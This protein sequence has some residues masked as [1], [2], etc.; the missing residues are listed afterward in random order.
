MAD[1]YEYNVNFDFDSAIE[2]LKFLNTNLSKSAKE[3]KNSAKTIDLLAQRMEEAAEAIGLA[4][5]NFQSYLNIFKSFGSAVGTPLQMMKLFT[6]AQEDYNKAIAQGLN[7]FEAMEAAFSRS[8]V[9]KVVKDTRDLVDVEKQL[10][11]LK[12]ERTKF[13][14]QANKEARLRGEKIPYPKA[15]LNK[16]ERDA[17]DEGQAKKEEAARQKANAAKV[18]ESEK[19]YDE[20]DSIIAE[21]LSETEAREK[22]S[23]DERLKA[24]Q[25]YNKLIA[26][27]I[28]RSKVKSLTPEKIKEL[29]VGSEIQKDIESGGSQDLKAAYD[30]LNKELES[31][32]KFLNEINDIANSNEEAIANAKAYDKAWEDAQKELKEFN[33][34]QKKAADDYDNAWRQAHAQLNKVNKEAED[35]KTKALEKEIDERIQL[36]KE[37]ISFE[38]SLRDKSKDQVGNISPERILRASK[39]KD[40]LS[41]LDE[42]D[43]GFERISAAIKEHNAD[44]EKAALLQ[45]K[46]Q[47]AAKG[48]SKSIEEVTLS[49][50]AMGRIVAA[51]LITQVFFEMQSA[52]QR[53]VKEAADLYNAIAEIQTITER[54]SQGP[55]EYA[56]SLERVLDLSSRL[57]FTPQDTANAVY[58]ALSNQI[59]ETTGELLNFIEVSGR[60]AKT[61]RSSLESASDAIS[62]VLNAYNLSTQNSAQIAAQ[63]FTL[64]DQGRVKLEEIANHLGNVAVPASQLG[65]SFEHVAAS[66]SAI[67]IAGIPAR[68]SMTL[69]RNIMFKLIGPTEKMEGLFRQWGVSSGQAAIATFGF[70]GVL[71]KLAIEAEKG[72]A[73]IQELFGTIRAVRG[74]LGLTD[75]N[76][77]KYITALEATR[78]AQEEYNEIVEDYISNPGEQFNRLLQ[79]TSNEILAVGLRLVDLI[80]KF[81]AFFGKTGDGVFRLA[82]F[83]GAI[84]KAG[85]AIGATG[86]SFV[87][88]LTT[89]TAFSSALALIKTGLL[90]VASASYATTISVKALSAAFTLLTKHPVLLAFTAIITTL[91]AVIS[92][93][94]AFGKSSVQTFAEI[95]AAAQEANKDVNRAFTT[96]MIESMQTVQKVFDQKLRKTLKAMSQEIINL[97]KEI[98]ELE[99]VTSIEKITGDLEAM[100]DALN[101]TAADQAFLKA[102]GKADDIVKEFGINLDI[103]TQAIEDE[104]KALEKQANSIQ[105]VID[106][107]KDQRQASLDLVKANRL[108]TKISIT[109]RNISGLNP[110]AQAEANLNVAQNI[111]NEASGT[112]DIEESRELYNTARK[113]LKE[114]ESVAFQTGALGS[115]QNHIRFFNE[116][117]KALAASQERRE[118]QEQNSLSQRQKIEE[119]QQA[120]LDSKYDIN[121]AELDR[122]NLAEEEVNFNKKILE[123]YQEQF[124]V[125]SGSNDTQEEKNRKTNDLIAILEKELTLRNQLADLD[126]AVGNAGKVADNKLRAA[127]IL[128]NQ[129]EAIRQGDVQRGE[130]QAAQQLAEQAR[131]SVAAISGSLDT[132]ADFLESIVP[133][134]QATVSGRNI[135]G[136]DGI[137]RYNEG[138]RAE[139]AEN[140][141]LRERLKLVQDE[142]KAIQEDT[143]STPGELVS[144]IE[145]LQEVITR[146]A[147]KLPEDDG[148]KKQLDD[149]AGKLATAKL[150]SAAAA[151][152]QTGVL[153]TLEINEALLATLNGPGGYIAVIQ[154]NTDALKA[155]TTAIEEQIEK[156]G[157][158]SNISDQEGA[159]ALQKLFPETG[160]ASG[161][162]EGEVSRAAIEEQQRNIEAQKQN[163][164]ADQQ[165]IAEQQQAINQLIYQEQQRQR[166]PKINGQPLQRGANGPMING[167]P[168]NRGIGGPKINGVPYFDQSPQ[169]PLVNG[170]PLP[171]TIIGGPKI[172][173]VPFFDQGP[174]EPSASYGE[175]VAGGIEA[176]AYE[177]I[178]RS[179]EQGSLAISQAVIDGMTEAFRR[180]QLNPSVPP[181]NRNPYGAG[182][183]PTRYYAAGG[184]VGT[185]TIPA[186]LS[187]GEYVIRASQ[188]RQHFSLLSAINSGAYRKGYASG[189]PVT[190]SQTFTNQFNLSTPSPNMQAAVIANM[191]KRQVSQGKATFSKARPY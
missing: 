71:A 102:I 32:V 17:Y 117:E 85:L 27:E 139:N 121:Q 86:T 7:H 191:I 98:S 58:E 2:A 39:G 179:M 130:S 178:P 53:S 143:T 136:R 173:G 133:D 81:A 186:W 177:S 162:E 151:D 73:E 51:R 23:F 25:A 65:V 127:Q 60:L 159:A 185:D 28:D 100:S 11:E 190:Q 106:K 148:V 111:A 92:Y 48:T 44:L 47:D 70:E 79:Q 105:Q 174:S 187:P 55:V 15:G 49:W 18:K 128:K 40:S 142:I 165:L 124:K 20:L 52:I 181:V 61:T 29:G 56:I 176:G 8:N 137:G 135:F 69:M 3:S 161:E 43:P 5:G 26:G 103:T 160:K 78:K 83:A 67:S 96:G 110:R 132:L 107:L 91:T 188:A 120:E 180:E 116:Q 59:G 64:V 144:R 42:S 77:Q 95:A 24:L 149:L 45:R 34:A 171:V 97:E 125:I 189:G 54:A 138:V 101:G 146:I 36:I 46:Y 38:A 37:F 163:S 104:N 93:T 118:S 131:T 175:A 87:L 30:E 153:T 90:G 183:P 119:S 108:N 114:A 68:E 170:Q 147:T 168:L 80:N 152:A 172:D 13:E 31:S 1:D 22:K 157:E 129:D 72:N 84:A 50:K 75:E 164:L 109:E 57:N 74:V 12:K 76:F 63:L 167:Q 21:Y 115:L 154:E 126:T 41:S 35:E 145:K 140:E 82:E 19:I 166:E 99:S 122:R 4:G 113:F 89:A 16:A 66:L 156:L 94:A 184:P 155:R 150:E 158:T 169:G 88:A 33:T 112:A 6:A 14:K 141:I 10:L 134:V 123:Y 9:E 182:E 62:S